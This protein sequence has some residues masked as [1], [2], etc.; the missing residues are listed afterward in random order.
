MLR[1]DPPPL[2]AGPRLVGTFLAWGVFVAATPGA[3]F[4]DG[5]VLLA[6]LAVGLWGHVE[7]RSYKGKNKWNFLAH[8]L[9]T[10]PGACGLMW[11]IVKVY[12]PPLLYIGLGMGVY[13][14]AGGVLL[15]R[16]ARVLPAGATPLAIA[17]AWTAMETARSIMPLP[18]GLGWMRVGYHA[19]GWLWL[20]GSARLWGVAGLTFA[21]AA[22]GGYA[23]FAWR[24]RRA[25]LR[26]VSLACGLA[27][28]ALGGLFALATRPPATVD[29]PRLLL[30]QPGFP[31]WRKMKWDARE[32][33]AEL[34][35]Q[36]AD[37]LAAVEARGEPPPDVVC[38]GESML[39]VP[40]VLP[41][42][43]P[44]AADGPGVREG[45]PHNRADF[46]FYSALER[47][48]V[49]ARILP[50]L[51]EGTSFL[52][53]VDVLVAR[54]GEV[55]RLG[56]AVL[57]D[58]EGRRSQPAG[59]RFLVPG[60][61]TMY[62]L[63]KLG[64]VRSFIRRVSGYVPDLVAVERTEVLPIATRAGDSLGAAVTVC[65]DNA[66]LAPY[67]DPVRD[68]EVD[69]HVV[70]SNEAWYEESFEVDQMI[71]FSRIAALASG[72]TLVRATNS[73][74]SMAIG[75]DGR[76]L[77]RIR[78]GE[79]DRMIAGFLALTVPVPAPGEAG[80]P[81]ITGLRPWLP[82]LWIGVPLILAL[83]RRRTHGNHGGDGG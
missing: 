43:L 62:G 21:L 60:A 82:V 2:A 80:R 8:V 16:V 49:H 51:P 15:R 56:G 65:F 50:T 70:V 55:R 63:E 59:K 45:E 38:W 77:G 79:K 32:N 33:F 14:A 44:L 68:G 57:Y 26:P 6:A 41:E 10:V 5:S 40:I 20:A 7:L 81:P 3:L 34:V 36:T 71:A 48:W 31:Q 27:P 64:P 61:E 47:E 11:W 30:I 29:G 13:S 35:R 39:Q 28:L 37:A 66:H 19:H 76:E 69:F 9:G 74:I 12:P 73:G 78:D 42:V 67:T 23:A 18:L 52:T 4:A 46:D 24:A 22:L 17:L 54:G 75:P 53:G 83:R 25:A 72:R 58:P 1:S